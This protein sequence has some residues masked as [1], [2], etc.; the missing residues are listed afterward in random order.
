[1]NKLLYSD[2]SVSQ[3]T[4]LRHDAVEELAEQFVDTPTEVGPLDEVDLWELKLQRLKSITAQLSSPVSADIHRN[5]QQ[6]NSSYSPALQTI[7]EDIDK[8]ELK[9]RRVSEILIICHSLPR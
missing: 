2:I 8:V 3:Q 6:A 9:V 1:M 7:Q 4:V 5:L